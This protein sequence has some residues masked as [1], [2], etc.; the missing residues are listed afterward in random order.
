MKRFYTQFFIL[1]FLSCGSA[2]VFAQGEDTRK[3]MD[4]LKIK[5]R[6]LEGKEKIDANIRLASLLFQYERDADTIL[7][8]MQLFYEEGIK[9]EDYAHAGNVLRNTHSV[10][11][12]FGMY[13]ESLKRIEKDLDFLFE[14][15]LWGIYYDL[16]RKYAESL[17]QKG[18]FGKAM[19]VA[20]KMYDQAHKHN[21]KSGI[22]SSLYTIGLLHSY[23]ERCEEA[24]TFFKEA[25]QIADQFDEAP[26]DKFYIYLQLVSAILEVNNSPYLSEIP[27]ILTRWEADIKRF[28]SIGN[29]SAKN[30]WL[31]FYSQNLVYY[32][33]GDVNYDKIAEYCNLMEAMLQDH[34]IQGFYYCYGARFILAE[35]DKDWAKMLHYAQQKLDLAAKFGAGQ[36]CQSEGDLLRALIHLNRADEAIESLEKFVA[37]KDTINNESISKQLSELRTVYEVDIHIAEKQKARLSFYFAMG[38]GVLLLVI[39]IIWILYSRKILKKNIVLADKILAQENAQAEIEKLKKIAQDTNQTIPQTDE[40]FTRLEN[41]MREQKPYIEADCNRKKLADIVG[42]NEKYISES[43]KNNTDL[44]VSEYIMAYRLKHANS[45]LLRSSAEYTIDAVAADSGFGSRSKFHEHYRAHYGITP[46][47]FRKAIESKR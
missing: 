10:Y 21:H 20:N 36:E 47:E 7:H 32:E 14:H 33:K 31:A 30:N 46:N 24:I 38:I 8:Y 35:K 22:M 37:L 6:T 15:E 43:I 11:R 3:Q 29:Y 45:L 40:I 27:E 12:N 9:Y 39:L 5:T 42:T 16:Y 2:F 23:H 18:D 25:L 17:E 34:D 44:S 26:M 1:Y 13:D 41:L 28:E 4:S 19:E